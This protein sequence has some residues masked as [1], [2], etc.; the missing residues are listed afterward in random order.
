[1]PPHGDQAAQT[2]GMRPWRHGLATSASKNVQIAVQ[3][4]CQPVLFYEMVDV[5]EPDRSYDDEVDGNDVY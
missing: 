3:A 1:M 5:V 4:K 2:D